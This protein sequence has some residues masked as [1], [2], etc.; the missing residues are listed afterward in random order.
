MRRVLL[1]MLAA[2]A[3]ASVS[4]LISARAWG[5]A[6]CSGSANLPSLITSDSAYQMGFTAGS[7]TVIGSS[8]SDGSS[9]FRREGNDESTLQFRFAAAHAVS[10]EFQIHAELPFS[11]TYRAIDSARSTHWGPGDLTLGAA[12]EVV[13]EFVYHPLR[14][15]VWIFTDLTFPT[16]RSVY[17]STEPMLTDIHGRGAW[18]VSVGAFALK[19]WIPWEVHLMLQHRRSF[20]RFAQVLGTST[21]VT[22]GPITAIEAG[23]G[24]HLGNF[25][26]GAAVNPT[27]EEPTQLD[28]APSSTP[29]RTK[30]VWTVSLQASA[31]LSDLWSVTATY[32]DQTLLGPTYNAT[33]ARN[34]NLSVLY[35]MD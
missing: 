17:E 22:L 21:Q 33:L 25:R 9:I 5:A 34:L 15:R 29:G 11:R 28:P 20:S 10:P 35:R 8:F 6:C 2:T 18:A 13:Q 27:W 31:A 23:T 32:A 30:L 12:Y 16:G 4:V 14:P 19:T 26:L 7:E 1:L 24:Y 3:S